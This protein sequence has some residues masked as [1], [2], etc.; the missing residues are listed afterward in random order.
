MILNPEEQD[1]MIEIKGS[2]PIVSLQNILQM[3]MPVIQQVIQNQKNH[4]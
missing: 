2:G 3:Q 1:A 4:I